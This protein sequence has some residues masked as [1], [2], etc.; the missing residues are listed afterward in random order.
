MPHGDR[1]RRSP[2]SFGERLRSVWSLAPLA[3]L[4]ARPD[5]RPNGVSAVVRVRGEEEW[6]EPCLRSIEGFADEILVLDNGADPVTAGTLTRLRE[7]L[8]PRLRIE[9]CPELDLV[10]LSNRG[11]EAARRRWVIRW[12]ADFVARTDGEHDIGR[13]REFLL[14]LDP[15]R[16][17]AVYLPAVEVAGDLAH[18]FPDRRVR[19]DGAVH[20]ASPH[21]RYVAVARDLP[22]A[23]LPYPDRVL[24]EGPSLRVRFESIRLPRYYRVHTW[25]AASYMHVDVKSRRHMLLRHFW[26]EW[27]RAAANG[28][29]MTLEAYALAQAADRGHTASPAAA[30]DALVARYCAGLVPFDAARCGPYPAAL[31]PY[32]ER[33]R[34]RV[35]YADGRAVGRSER[36]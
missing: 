30:A 7:V 26:L 3:G 4:V 35:E 8:G 34:Y 31:R 12:D 18:Q 14:A 1:G 20:T 16:Y 17:H 27:Y 21:A 36:D 6:L 33:P 22:L 32:L 29:S 15:R 25:E 2:M 11:L 10:A 5:D 19:R 28:P 23:S 24:R 9:R 13:L